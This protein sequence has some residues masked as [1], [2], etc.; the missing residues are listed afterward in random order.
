MK[1]GAAEAMP[2][3]DLVPLCLWTCVGAGNAGELGSL[4]RI[5]R[6]L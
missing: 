2:F 4:G 6:P 5:S 1:K 3:S